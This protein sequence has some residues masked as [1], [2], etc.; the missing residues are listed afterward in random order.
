[1]SPEDDGHNKILKELLTP[2][3][4]EEKISHWAKT[5]RIIMVPKHLHDHVNKHYGE[6]YF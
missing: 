1:V 4:P 3:T 5:D 6:L 2:L